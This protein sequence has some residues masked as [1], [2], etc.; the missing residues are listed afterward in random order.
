MQCISK[1]I[2]AVYLNFIPRTIKCRNSNL[3]RYIQMN[4]E[5]FLEC[6]Y[7]DRSIH[8]T[9]YLITAKIYIW[10]VLPFKIKHLYELLYS[11]VHKCVCILAILSFTS[12]ASF[13]VLCT[14]KFLVRICQIDAYMVKYGNCDAISNN[15]KSNGLSQF[16]LP[17]FL[18]S[19]TWYTI[20]G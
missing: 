11:I 6:W 10:S 13:C 9:C 2:I 15:I 5:A 7:F 19:L 14:T 20:I 4:I 16:P 17:K 12:P 8:F 3:N 18:F 1:Y